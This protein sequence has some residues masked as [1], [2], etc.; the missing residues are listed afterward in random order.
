MEKGKTGQVYNLGSDSQ[1]SIVNLA[2]LV[3]EITGS[4]SKIKF[5]KRPSHDHQTRL[6]QLLKV[7][8]LGWNPIKDLK[9]GLRKT[10]QNLSL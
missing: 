7:R 4:K 6:P 2:E 10:L 5:T 9:V 1:I 3:L 8:Q